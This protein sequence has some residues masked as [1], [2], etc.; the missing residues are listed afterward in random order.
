MITVDLIT[1]FD[2]AAPFILVL[3][4][5]AGLLIAG[6]V[7]GA[8]LAPVRVRA[9]LS[10]LLALLIFPHQMDELHPGIAGA[11]FVAA[12]FLELLVGVFIGW[13]AR[14]FLHGLRFGGDLIGRIAGFAAAEVF[15]P[16][17]ESVGGPIGDIVWTTI[18][19]LYLATDGHHHMLAALVGSF[20]MIPLGALTI[21]P[22]LAE[23]TIDASDR[24][25]DI[26]LALAMPTIMAIL[27]ISVAEGV[28]ARAVP[29]INILLMSFGIKIVTSWILLYVSLPA[30]VAFFG[31][32]LNAMQTFVYE[33]LPQ[34]AAG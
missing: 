23:A 22:G 27:V 31:M 25:F 19:V 7:L 32:V 13:C 9:G 6:P 33:L 5:C 18:V 34:L 21:G 15:N 24:V 11:G 30:A 20:T 8:D 28:V 2:W 26:G 17:T 3:T 14:C 10:L 4:R 1:F 29:Q 16:A 12:L